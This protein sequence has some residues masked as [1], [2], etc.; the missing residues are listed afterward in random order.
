MA[1]HGTLAHLLPPTYKSL[2]SS[3]LHEDCPSFDYGGFVVGDAPAK[4]RLLGKS[5]GIVAGIPFFSE[6]FTQL[7]CE[8]VSHPPR[9]RYPE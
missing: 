5:E 3:W 4:A 6:V 2:I 9:H 7:G 1:T 8:C